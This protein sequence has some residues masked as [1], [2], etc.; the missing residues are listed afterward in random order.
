MTL[1]RMKNCYW[2]WMPTTKI[3]NV[4]VSGTYWVHRFDD[5]AAINYPTLA[6]SFPEPGT[7]KTFYIGYRYIQTETRDGAYVI[8]GDDWSPKLIDHDPSTACGSDAIWPVG[9]TLVDNGLRITPIQVGG[10]AP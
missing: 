10:T 4:T 7:G 1:A 6:L 8:W 2:E 3:K 9:S 5:V